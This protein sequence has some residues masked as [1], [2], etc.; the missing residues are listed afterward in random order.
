M[1]YLLHHKPAGESV[2][3]INPQLGGVEPKY[4]DIDK[5]QV[6]LGT[7]KEVILFAHAFI[8]TDTTSAAYRRGKA[9]ACQL[10]KT[11]RDEMSIFYK[12]DAS[13]EEISVA[14]EHFFLAWYGA[15][16]FAS[17][18]IARFFKLREMIANQ[19]VTNAMNLAVLP[20]T[21]GSAKQHSMRAYLLIHQCQSV[22]LDCT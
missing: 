6:S 5:L 16:N 8:G 14:G 13:Q 11:L 22:E 1:I 18:N 21:S 7:L 2:I 19:S 17:L 15:E 3:L 12:K 4:V 9:Q 20:P 10:L